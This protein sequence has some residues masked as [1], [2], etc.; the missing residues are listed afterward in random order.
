MFEVPAQRWADLS[1][2]GYGVALLND[3]KYG[4]DTRDNVMRLT[5]LRA[6]KSPGRTADVNKTHTF[7]Y[8]L[9]PHAGVFGPE[10]VR[11]GYEL[12]VPV[13]ARPAR[14][15]G[16]APDTAS[17]LSVSNPRAVI[18]TVKRAED[19]DGL[20][21]R[22]YEACGGRGPC[23]LSL[24]LPFKRVYETNLMEKVERELTAKAGAVRF[25]LGPFEIKTFKFVGVRA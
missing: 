6:P 5:L 4:Y 20:I 15:S 17:F 23:S 16:G 11:A 12:N 19:D 3:C 14:R 2:N 24:S 18:E 22:V 7:T 25:G 10:V 8:A 13:L 1:E 9:L 21:V